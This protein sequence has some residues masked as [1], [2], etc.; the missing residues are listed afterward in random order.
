MTP[1]PPPLETQ[2]ATIA[3]I[4]MGPRGVS[5]L[6]R[7]IASSDESTPLH[8]HV[9]DPWQIGAGE[10]WRTDQT[11][12]M[13]MNTLAHA[14][15][16]YTE[17][18]ATIA[19]PI[20]PG[21]TMYEWAVGV[22]TGV[23]SADLPP[24]LEEETHRTRPES[25]PSRALYGAYI[26]WVYE[27]IPR[28]THVTLVEHHATATR[29]TADGDADFIELSDGTTVRAHATVYAP[30]WVQ[31]QHTPPAGMTGRW[32][33]PGNPIDQPVDTIAAGEDVLLRGLGMG[34]F[35]AVTLLTQGRGGRHD[36]ERYHP[37]GAEP[38]IRATSRR[39]YPFYP[40]SEYESLPPRP[41]LTRL[42]RALAAH[43]DETTVDFRVAI[44]P[45]V[46]RDAYEAYYR[47]LG[48]VHP[49]RLAL[50][51]EEI[52]TRIDA[53]APE[54]LPTR[55]ADA[56]VDATD[57]WDHRAEF[58]PLA[59]APDTPDE[60]HRFLLHR[61]RRDAADSAQG[62]L[63]PRKAALWT[64]SASRKLVSVFGEQGRYTADSL[65][66]FADFM[67]F[68]QMVGSGPPAF[69][70]RELIR[71][72]EAGIVTFIH[73]EQAAH[74]AATADVVLDAF[75]PNPDLRTTGDPLMRQLRDTGRLQPFAPH[76]VATASPAVDPTT[77]LVAGD[78]RLHLLGIP[79]H[80]QFADMSI[81]PMPGT[82]PTMLRE[83]DAAARS[84]LAIALQAAH[85]G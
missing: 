30:G 50:P 4:G 20:R 31:P 58:N 49:E 64:L 51:L 29:I 67:A 27:H 53:T 81:S 35:D 63:S 61:L 5:T 68:G 24:H 28:P 48:R 82:D 37:S 7:L 13:C 22:R 42:Q 40:K 78:A 32:I 1:T 62:A 8:I 39:G 54:E 18:G 52:L 77:R 47:T 83:T 33:A 14:V 80:A 15:T 21:P 6:E 17:P 65:P 41:Q 79:T 69:R 44:A 85:G 9:I 23:L 57:V 26:R 60:F 19:G 16:L 2:P 25:H 72:V 10:L 74:A 70:T 71:L 66:A 59:G 38:R 36:A 3:L 45:A 76:G 56:T 46:L 75:L 55:L 43:A 11:D 73:P 12:L 84:A 34:F